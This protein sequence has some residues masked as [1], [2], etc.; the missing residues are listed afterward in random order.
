MANVSNQASTP[1]HPNERAWS[2]GPLAFTLVVGFAYATGFLIVSTYLDSYGIPEET[3]DFLKLKYLQVGLY[4]LLFFGSIVVLT[5][6]LIRAFALARSSEQSKPEEAHGTAIA[7]VAANEPSTRPS[8]AVP[9]DPGTPSP[10]GSSVVEDAATKL[11][12]ARQQSARTVMFAL[13]VWIEFLL[14][15]YVTVGFAEPNQTGRESMP[16]VASLVAVCF[17]SMATIYWLGRDLAR[18]NPDADKI[19]GL[20]YLLVVLI[21]EPYLGWH[22]IRPFDGKLIDFVK[23]DSEPLLILFILLFTLGFLLYRTVFPRS[24][25][26]DEEHRSYMPLRIALGLPLY[27][28]CVLTFA[29]SIYPFMSVSKAGGYFAGSEFVRLTLREPHPKHTSEGCQARGAVEPCIATN[30]TGA[31][32]EA[33]QVWSDALPKALMESNTQSKPLV[34]I[35]ENST[36]VFVADPPDPTDPPANSSAPG[37]VK[38]WTDFQCRPTVYEIQTSSL[39]RIDH[40]PVGTG[41]R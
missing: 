4:F 28:L 24:E 25:F 23:L 38:C 41:Q 30:G 10:R 36:S 19:A 17:V 9:S 37:G 6:T 7:A 22:V 2:Y 31:P 15:I 16:W 8:A 26:G 20:L 29:Y 14:F 11:H 13:P 5:L 3:N 21:I 12:K 27:Y 33:S 39:T 32:A 18:R 1:S 40:I 34:L 35:E